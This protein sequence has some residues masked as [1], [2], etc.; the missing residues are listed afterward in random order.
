MCGDGTSG[1]VRK[2]N[3]KKTC[4]EFLFFE[5]VNEKCSSDGYCVGEIDSSST[6]TGLATFAPTPAS[7]ISKCDFFR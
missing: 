4:A 3:K 7:G 1:L 6:P 2:T 5:K